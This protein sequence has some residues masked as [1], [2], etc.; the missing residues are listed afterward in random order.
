MSGR[1]DAYREVYDAL[2]ATG[3]PWEQVNG[4]K[5][6]KLYLSGHLVGILP[7]GKASTAGGCR[8][9]KN[10]AARIKHAAEAIKSKE[11]AKA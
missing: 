8:G 9:N 1:R 7:H 6:V 5:H 11:T 4:K 10:F 2:D 3:L